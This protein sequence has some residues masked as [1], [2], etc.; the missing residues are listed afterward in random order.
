M[1]NM[2]NLMISFK[3]YEDASCQKICPS[4]SKF[5]TGAMPS[6][7]VNVIA[8]TL[9]FSAGMLPFNYL[10]VPVFN[11]KPRI[12]YL[13]PITDK[14]KVKLASW[15]GS[16]ISIMGRDQLVKSKIHEMIVYSFHCYAWPK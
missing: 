8:A 6:R 9:G 5:F 10:G 15:K 2:Q 7:R 1:R 3:A 11:G 14:I 12:S 16:L 4:K 13:L